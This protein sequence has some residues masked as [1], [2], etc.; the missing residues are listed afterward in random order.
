MFQVQQEFGLKRIYFA[1]CISKAVV[2]QITK[3]CA[4]DLAPKG[5]RLNAINP[6]AIRTEIF[7]NTGNT[8]EEAENIFHNCKNIYPLGRVGECQDTTAVIEY[9]ISDSASFI[10]EVLFKIDGGAIIAGK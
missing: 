2:H 6:V 1:Y 7:E 8:S 4:L 9:L 10:T 5:I 3:C